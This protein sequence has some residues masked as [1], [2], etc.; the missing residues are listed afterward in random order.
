M[1]SGKNVELMIQ[2]EGIS[3]HKACE[4]FSL[5]FSYGPLRVMLRHDFAFAFYFF[6]FSVAK[7]LS[8]WSG[9]ISRAQLMCTHNCE[10][11]FNCCQLEKPFWLAQRMFYMPNRPKFHN[12]SSPQRTNNEK[13]LNKK[14]AE[15]IALAPNKTATYCVWWRVWETRSEHW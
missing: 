2:F 14:F 12:C 13:Q 6:F 15:P 10:S 7:S 9:H 3:G 4:P 11:A 5:L 8:R 1:V